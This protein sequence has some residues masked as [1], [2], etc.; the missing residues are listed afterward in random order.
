MSLTRRLSLFEGM[1]MGLV[2]VFLLMFSVA[3]AQTEIATAPSDIPSEL[4]LLAKDLGCQT[5][6]ECAEKFDANLEQGITLAQKYDIYTPEQEKVASTFKT[7]VLERLR[8]VSQDNFEEEILA[9]ANKILSEKPSL[10]R[11]M[12]LTRQ[13]VSAAE[14]V[15]NTVKDAGVD[16]RTCQKS[17]ENLSRE[18]LI[19]CVKAGNDLSSKGT[20]V[21]DYIPKENVKA[22][23]AQ[24]MLDLENSLLAGEYSGLG[25]IGV[26]QAGQVCLKPG[27]E[28]IA[29]CDRIAQRFFGAEGLKHLQEARQQTTRIKEYYTEGIERMELVTPDGQKLIGK[30]AIKNACNSAFEGNNLGLAR[31][32]GNF[33][34]KNGYATQEEIEDG[35]KLLDTFSQKAQGVNF[36][37][38]RFNPQSCREFLPD[39]SRSQFDSQFEIFRIM[40]ESIGFDPSRCE[41]TYDSDIGKRCLEGAKNALS[42]VEEI[43]KNSPEARRIV[44][45]IR[46]HI[47]E[48]ERMTERRDE[49]NQDLSGGGMAGPGGCRGPEECFKYCSQATNSAECISF[50]AKSQIFDQNSV[51]QRFNIVNERNEGFDYRSF[52]NLPDSSGQFGQEVDPGFNRY[53]YPQQP[54]YPYP[55]QQ[56][57][58]GFNRYPYP[59]QPVGPSPECLAAI[60]SGDFA[61]AKTACSSTTE[62]YPRPIAEPYPMCPYTAM[63]SPCPEGQMR[64]QASDAR[65]CPTYG[66]CTVIENYKPIDTPKP[67]STETYWNGTSCVAYQQDQQNNCPMMPTVDSC[68]AGQEKYETYSAK[69]CGVYYGCRSTTT[70]PCPS[71]QYWDGTACVTQPTTQCSSGQWWDPATQSCK[72]ST[73]PTVGSCSYS[74]QYWKPSTSQC[75]PR[76]NC[77]DTAN[78]EYN[79]QEC[80]GVRG[81]TQ[82]V[83]S[84]CGSYMAQAACQAVSGCGWANGAC[85]GNALTT[86]PTVGSCSY[87]TQYWKASTSQC[88]PR[89]NCTDTTNAEYNSSECQGVRGT[90]T[91]CPSGQY[92]FTPP[93][94]GAGYCMSST[95]SG[96]CPAGYHSHSESGGFC[97]N[98][99]ENYSGTCY[100]S[101]GTATTTC[102]QQTYVPPVGSGCGTYTSQTSCSSAPACLWQNN[103]CLM[104]VTTC[105]YGQYWNGTACVTSTTSTTCPSGQHWYTPSS[106]AGYCISDTTGSTTCPSGQSWYT[107]PSGGTGYC[108]SSTTY[109]SDPATA[110]AQGGGTW[111]TS[112]NYCQMS[113]TYPTPS[114]TYPTPSYITPT[115]SYSTPSTTYPTPSTEY[116]T[117]STTY[118]TPS[119]EYPTPSYVTPPAYTTPPSAMLLCNQSGGNWTGAACN[120][121]KNISDQKAYYSYYQKQSS[122]LLAQV[123]RAFADLFK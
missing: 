85:G 10:A 29:D 33:A 66:A 62:N 75:L 87:S 5:S 15:I 83:S 35:L 72:S 119:T 118:P 112:T 22:G 30:G 97:M 111:N 78:S 92:W 95:A 58:P 63:P 52:P 120:L 121:A 64:Q 113:T 56:P 8:T 47:T 3:L 40:S 6:T 116:P 28:S 13:T 99:Q 4:I 123:I 98:D 31:A 42:R 90:T 1:V 23:E 60:S 7:E 77:T 53:P 67:C 105:V 70:T 69:G 41:N 51:V 115:E 44:N 45:E 68:P 11:T 96:S 81:M 106:G 61:K 50:G 109:S 38:C 54:P 103:V 89:T 34:V 93:S 20:L 16:I 101:A 91:T 26:E 18:Q 114:T 27:S 14:T 94:G 74:T 36:D 32:C 55:P 100:N 24:Q 25:Q 2:L 88:M 12:G 9:L 79:S 21:G 43:A 71:G 17:P 102:P 19:A 110:C 76:T 84:G 80:Q 82:P 107:P 46:S 104:N 37:D 57:D 65:G 39:E 49:F 73:T 108:Q 86:V 48:G 117:P 59:Q 122:P